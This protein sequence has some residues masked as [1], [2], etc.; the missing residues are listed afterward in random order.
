MPV[1]KQALDEPLADKPGSSRER[2]FHLF[3]SIIADSS[4]GRMDTI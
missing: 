4:G 1:R 2:H 3:F